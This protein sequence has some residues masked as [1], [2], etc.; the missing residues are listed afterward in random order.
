MT[1]LMEIPQAAGQS[2]CAAP[3]PPVAE[4]DYFSVSILAPSPLEATKNISLIEQS[5]GVKDLLPPLVQEALHRSVPVF[6][7]NVLHVFS[8]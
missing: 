5:T 8:R 1:Q 4:L 6:L 2:D 7:V 3:D